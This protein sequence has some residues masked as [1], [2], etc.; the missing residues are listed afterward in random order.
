MRKESRLEPGRQRQSEESFNSPASNYISMF[1]DFILLL[2][3]Y[4][5]ELVYHEFDGFKEFMAFSPDVGGMAPS[6]VGVG[7]YRIP[8]LVLGD[9]N[10]QIDDVVSG[11]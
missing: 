10:L 1:P 7:L 6:K 9:G 11:E 3:D 8:V 4:V 5:F 2:P